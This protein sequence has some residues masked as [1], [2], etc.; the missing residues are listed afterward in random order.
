MSGSESGRPL[1][2]VLIGLHLLLAAVLLFVSLL[3]HGQVPGLSADE[4]AAL[5][6]LFFFGIGIPAL[7]IGIT[8]LVMSIYL[9]KRI[10]LALAASMLVTAV[11]ALINVWTG[12]FASLCYLS[13][14][15]W[16]VVQRSHG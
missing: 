9:G 8:T 12:L 13:M 2:S 1:E 4:S 3:A 7:L 6:F 16:A 11:F 14:G 10:F 15:I 5:G